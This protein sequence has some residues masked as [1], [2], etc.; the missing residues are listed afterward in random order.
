LRCNHYKEGVGMVFLPGHALV[1]GKLVAPNDLELAA[2]AWR[3][4]ETHEFL[5]AWVTETKARKAV[6]QDAERLAVMVKEERAAREVL[7]E[8]HVRELK[9]ERA[10]REELQYEMNKLREENRKLKA[11][12]AKNG[13]SLALVQQRGELSPA[14]G[15]GG[16][17]SE[18]VPNCPK[19]D[20]PVAPH[21][22]DGAGDVL[23]WCPHCGDDVVVS[24]TAPLE[25]HGP[26]NHGSWWKFW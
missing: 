7:A 12:L 2:A 14:N 6:E 3:S 16:A 10:R 26:T 18:A 17:L 20:L 8:S 9:K 1:D 13:I 4:K 23:C 22:S 5:D 15:N 24:A 21:D 25:D 19:C 11:Q